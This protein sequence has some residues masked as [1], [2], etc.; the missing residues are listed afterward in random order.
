M[1]EEG[2]YWVKF[3]GRDWECA[4]WFRSGWWGFG[5]CGIDDVSLD[6][7]DERRI[8]LEVE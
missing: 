3:E 7:I 4:E 2:W 5:F 8:V 1:R 6:E